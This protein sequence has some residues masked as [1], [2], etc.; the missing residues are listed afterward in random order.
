ME[1][2]DVIQLK[3]AS[4]AA[5]VLYS[6]GDLASQFVWTFIGS[7]LTVFYTDIVGLAPAIAAVIMMT[8]RI[9]DAINDPI[10]CSP[11][12]QCVPLVAYPSF[13]FIPFR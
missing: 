10:I 13:R 3:R 5:V 7:Y 6:L 1:N 11:T 8:A 12:L 9:W 2:K 4:K